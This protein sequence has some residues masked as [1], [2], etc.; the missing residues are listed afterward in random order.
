[1][2]CAT[3]LSPRQ[4]PQSNSLTRSEQKSSHLRSPVRKTAEVGPTTDQI[5]RYW[6]LRS[7]FMRD[8]LRECRVIVLPDR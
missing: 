3:G 4:A 5:R 8:D 1:M 6:H 2:Q 7:D